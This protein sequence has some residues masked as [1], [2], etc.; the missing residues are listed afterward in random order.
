MDRGKKITEIFG[1]KPMN[2]LQF[3][4][5]H[6]IN[7]FV[8]VQYLENKIRQFHKLYLDIYLTLI[9]LQIINYIYNNIRR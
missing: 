6:K 1:M 8:L 5:F 2:Q 9:G 7:F 3:Y 4:E